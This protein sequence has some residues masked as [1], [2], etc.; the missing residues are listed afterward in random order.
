MF[1]ASERTLLSLR[2]VLFLL[3]RSRNNYHCSAA[4]LASCP[5]GTFRAL[6]AGLAGFPLGTF[7]ARGSSCPLCASRALWAGG[8]WRCSRCWRNIDYGGFIAGTQAE[9]C[10]ERCK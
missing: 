5:L 9:R 1:E 4:S 2:Q 7:I 10:D 3:G 8:T 6:R